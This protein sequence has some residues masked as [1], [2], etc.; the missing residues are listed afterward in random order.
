VL[1]NRPV[2][3]EWQTASEIEWGDFYRAVEGRPLRP[4]FVDAIP[5]LPT[6]TVG[7][8]PLVAVDLGCGDGTET[9][10]LLKRGWTVF[11]VDGSPEG[12][13]RIRESVPLVD[14]ERLTTR[15]ASFA[16]VRLPPADL[17]YAGLSL[18]FCHPR[19]F[20]A[21]WRTVASA[22]RPDGLFVGHV[23]GP[24]DSWADKPDMTFHTREDVETMFAEF[25]IEQLHEQDEDGEAVGGPKHWHVFHVIAR[26]RA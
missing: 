14:L 23:F 9:L 2:P 21:V 15:V 26:K 18:P 25:E 17:V 20:A 12:I 8:P 11:A 10:E 22:L 4:L 16:E 1:D 13:A 3:E 24:H 5:F 19:D 6:T 7:E